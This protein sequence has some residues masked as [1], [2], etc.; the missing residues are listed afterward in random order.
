MSE[1]IMNCIYLKIDGSRGGKE[2]LHLK[3]I[4]IAFRSSRRCCC[5]FPPLTSKTLMILTDETIILLWTKFSFT[6]LEIQ[7]FYVSKRQVT[8]QIV[9]YFQLNLHCTFPH[10]MSSSYFCRIR[11]ALSQHGQFAQPCKE[12]PEMIHA[13]IIL[14]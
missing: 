9:V 6:R 13:N 14:L 3:G 7:G 8:K 2:Y 1:N 11:F 4:F 10:V 12:M 5:C